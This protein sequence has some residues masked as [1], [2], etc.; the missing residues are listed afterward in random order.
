MLGGVEQE[1]RMAT[2]RRASIGDVDVV[3]I[4][5]KQ[6]F[7]ELGHPFPFSENDHLISFCKNLLKKG[8]YVVFLSFDYQNSACGMITLNEALSIYAGGNFGVIREFYVI[9]EIRSSGIGKALLS[10]AKEF[11]RSKGWTRIEVTPPHKDKWIRTYNFYMKEGF[12]EIGPRLKL[13][14]L[15]K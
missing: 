7:A 8:D 4:L 6:L 10:A 11:G 14:N 12:I 9:P 1:Y 15:N 3:I 2:I 13:E 5:S